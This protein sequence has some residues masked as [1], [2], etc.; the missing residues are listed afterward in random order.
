MFPLPPLHSP[1]PTPPYKP[2][3][4]GG[5]QWGGGEGGADE[6]PTT[7]LLWQPSTHSPE[8]IASPELTLVNLHGPRLL[9]PMVHPST[10]F[11]PSPQRELSDQLELSRVQGPTQQLC[12]TTGG[13]QSVPGPETSA[14]LWPGQ[15]QGQPAEASS[16]TPAWGWE[17]EFLNGWCKSQGPFGRHGIT[18]LLSGYVEPQIRK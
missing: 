15:D 12:V 9:L 7:A 2:Q 5:Q 8:G 14:G 6:T 17:E 18:F 1:T 4:W 13:A 10:A 11:L 16:P 3:L